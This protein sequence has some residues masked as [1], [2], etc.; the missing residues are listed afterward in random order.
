MRCPGLLI[1][2]GG[3]DIVPVST[4]RALAGASLSAG[5]R[6]CYAPL[7]GPVL[8]VCLVAGHHHHLLPPL[9]PPLVLLLLRV[10]T[11]LRSP[12]ATQIFP[13]FSHLT[14]S[15]EEEEEFEEFDEVRLSHPGDR[16]GDAAE[17]D[18]NVQTDWAKIYSVENRVDSEICPAPTNIAKRRKQI[19]KNKVSFLDNPNQSQTHTVF[20]ELNPAALVLERKLESELTD[21]EGEEIRVGEG[22]GGYVG[23]G[24]D[25]YPPEDRLSEDTESDEFTVDNIKS[26]WSNL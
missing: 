20:A 19:K 22:E 15:Y 24:Q 1:V 16:V 12:P 13:Y 6:P 11:T 5:V 17:D 10:K 9:P 21:M 2:D 23:E 18:E 26:K 14:S 3:P 25:T 4:C 7:T 8:A